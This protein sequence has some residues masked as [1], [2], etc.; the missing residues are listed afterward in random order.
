VHGS[1]CDAQTERKDGAV[2]VFN[3][4]NAV[5][6]LFYQ[7]GIA[8][9]AELE[10]LS[11][12]A[13]SQKR[14]LADALRS[15]GRINET[16]FAQAHAAS[17]SW[18]FHD[19]ITSPPMPDVL[20][21]L[22][23]SVARDLQ[24]VPARLDGGS[25]YVSCANPSDMQTQRRLQGQVRDYHVELV[26]SPADVIR[27]VIETSYSASAEAEDIARNGQLS[28]RGGT[29]ADVGNDLG[30]LSG[31]AND[32]VVRLVRLT[33]EQAVRD[34]G[35]DIHIEPNERSTIVRF[36]VDGV[37]KIA[38]RLPPEI[39]SRMVSYIKV[40]TG[41]RSDETRVGQD[42][43]MEITMGRNKI[44]IRVVTLPGVFG[45]D[46]IMRLQTDMARPLSEI[47]FSPHN[48]LIF[49]QAI[50][51]P[52][53]MVLV[54]GPTGSGKSTTLYSALREVQ[55]E[56]RKI[57][58]VEDPVETR[59]PPGITQVQVHARADWTFERALR[60][61]LRSDPDIILLGEI[62]DSITAKTAVDAA[63]TGHLLLST[64]HTNDAPGAL[65]R[66]MEL[67][68]AP[69]MAGESLLQVLAQ[70]LLRKL[71]DRCRVHDS[72]TLEG[73][74]A[75]GF[76]GV[77]EL[78]DKIFQARPGGCEHCRGVGYY[79]R[80]A[81]HEIMNLNEEIRALARKRSTV[82]EMA[83]AAADNGMLSLR[84]DGWY[85]VATGQTGIDE[86]NRVVAAEH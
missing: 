65:D 35:S 49:Q 67:G 24:V 79:G 18:A 81:V 15:Q 4:Q 75:A 84:D 83:R 64:L 59:M 74:H 10:R 55:S 29:S 78:P 27:K 72:I 5:I 86:V 51:Q 54:T 11:A 12:A 40:Q 23:P 77:T 17:Q 26:Y 50:A 39:G 16:Q 37:L 46:V 56:A 80:L 31:S 9:S 44:T 60:S 42:G 8:P 73:V 38:N 85:K 71:C 33:I 19:L 58:T 76:R 34:R 45:E 20:E 1:Y 22:P 43:P 47:G 69:S 70:R 21:L 25:L 32:E 2:E 57:I 7:L 68:V 41:M 53:G 66:L 82:A 28:D 13:A 36:R 30:D 48:L 6:K 3:D 14:T 61:I 52:H 62:R 63:M